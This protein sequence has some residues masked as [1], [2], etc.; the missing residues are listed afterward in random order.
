MRDPA[1]RFKLGQEMSLAIWSAFRDGPDQ[2]GFRSENASATV[3]YIRQA[4]GHSLYCGI[5]KHDNRGIPS[6]IPC[7]V[8]N[9]LIARVAAGKTAE[10]GELGTRLPLPLPLA[11]DRQGQAGRKHAAKANQEYSVLQDT[12]LQTPRGSRTIFL[13]S[14][15]DD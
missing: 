12:K 11:V 2:E 3:K 14:H 5:Q 15:A 13:V 10:E 4:A 8:R 9:M 7:P 1:T 6:S